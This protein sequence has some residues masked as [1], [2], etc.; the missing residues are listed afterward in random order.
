[1]L[2]AKGTSPKDKAKGVCDQSG[3]ELG[4]KFNAEIDGALV[5]VDFELSWTDMIYIYIYIYQIKT[6]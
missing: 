2:D 3:E 5:K 4:T 6:D 1:M